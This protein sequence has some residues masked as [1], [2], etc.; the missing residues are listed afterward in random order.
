MN[1]SESES[2][3]IDAPATTDCYMGSRIMDPEV[4]RITTTN[5]MARGRRYGRQWFLKGLCEGLRDSTVMQ[6]QLHKE[7]EIHSR[8]RHPSI[9]QVIGLED[10]DGLGLCIVEEWVDG[11]TLHEALAS[12][13]MK[14][15][16]K[17]HIIKNLIETVAYLHSHGVVH[18]DLKPSNIMI[19]DIGNEVAIIDFG[20]ADTSDY[21]EIKGAGGT[22]GFISP[23]QENSGGADPSDD[24]YSLGVIMKIMGTYYSRIARR[25]IAPVGK[26]PADA[27]QLLKMICRQDRIPKIFSG[28]IGA[29]ASI[30]VVALAT[31][32][33]HTLERSAYDSAGK[34]LELKAE[35]TEN[36]VRISSL[37]DSLTLM[38][39]HLDKANNELAR[40]ADYENLRNSIFN[41]GCQR[42]DDTL[43]SADRN[44]FSKISAGDLLSYNEKL[45]NL[46]E[47]LGTTIDDLCRRKLATSSLSTEDIESIRMNLYNYEGIKLSD[48]QEKW[49][50]R[51]NTQI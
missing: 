23:E 15:Y 2:G 28:I 48:Y 41:E 13:K 35:N 21:V 8:L 26:R 50:K 4:I 44:I 19:R 10:V 45:H 7:F 20:L 31:L 22:P 3:Y 1:T 12:R 18:R 51:I 16:E 42:I 38:K 27:G 47:N 11:V 40:I 34:V 36:L 14:S 29:V 32:H 25:C 30:V 46:V 37:N 39:E 24:V 17:R 49:L 5:I 43:I 9:V 6:R 33:I